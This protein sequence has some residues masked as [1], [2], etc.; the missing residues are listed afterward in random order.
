MKKALK[1]TGIAVAGVLLSIS[2]FAFIIFMV[3]QGGLLFLPNPPKPEITYGEF[4]ISVTC[5]VNGET[6]IIEDTVICEFDGFQ[7]EGE[8]GKHRKWKAHLKSGNEQLVLL[9]VD[10]TDLSYEISIFYGRPDYYMGD[11]RYGRQEDYEKEMSEFIYLG[12]YCWK[13]VDNL[14]AP[15]LLR[16]KHKRN[17]D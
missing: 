7:L 16:M 8:S 14:R 17:M 6:R 12:Y 3:F 15:L 5:E 10:D 13:K 11:F 2:L 1:I 4:P 9:R